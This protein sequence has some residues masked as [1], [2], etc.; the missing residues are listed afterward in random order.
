MKV[1]RGVKERAALIR[2]AR[3]ALEQRLGREPTLSEL[4]AE[5]G[6]TPEDIAVAETAT[7][8]AESLQR[9][10]G[11]KTSPSNRCWATTARRSAW[12]SRSP[13]ARLSPPCPSGSAR[14]SACAFSTT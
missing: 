7:G 3:T 13:C 5:T 14:S 2:S 10:S 9:E 4:S 11:K 12:S 6:I 8:P 1:S